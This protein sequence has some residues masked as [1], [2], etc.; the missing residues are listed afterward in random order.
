MKHWWLVVGVTMSGLW[1]T[2][3]C[4][5]GK[6]SGNTGGGTSSTG[7]S[8][9]GTGGQSSSASGGNGGSAADASAS[10][11]GGT[12]GNASGSGGAGT[13]GTAGTGGAN[14]GSAGQGGDNPGP[15]CAQFGDDCNGPD[16]CC[17]GI[18]DA[19]SDTCAR[20]T[21][22]CN[23]TGSNC[24]SN[25]DCCSF[26]CD[27]GECSDQP[28]IDDG[29]DCSASGASCCSGTCN[30]GTCDDVNGG[31]YTCLSAGNSCDDGSDCCSRLCTDGHCDLGSSYCTQLGD[32]CNSNADCCSGTCNMGDGDVGYCAEL[33]TGPNRCADGFAGMVCDGDCARCCSRACGPGP[34]GVVI[35][36]PPSGCRPAGELCQ[37]DTDC[38]GGDDE[39]GLPGSDSSQSFCE[40][41]NEG[42]VFGRCK[43][44]ACTPQGDVCQLNGGLCSEST[45][46]PSN[47]CPTNANPDNPDWQRGSCE[48]DTLGI[49]RCNGFTDDYCVP[50]GGSCSSTSDCCDNRPCVPDPNDN[51]RLKCGENECMESEEGCTTNADCCSGL[52]CVI[53]A[54]EVFG[55]CGDTTTTTTGSGGSGGT[56]GTGGTGGTGT[57]GTGGTTDECAAYGQECTEDSDCCFSAGT[58]QDLGVECLEPTPGTFRC[59]IQQ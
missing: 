47:C 39:A 40:R 6:K 21:L 55:S 58:D 38:C 48:F 44:Q 3:G 19:A 29:E 37:R 34:A 59:L 46:L 45:Q 11:S 7:G 12:A 17:S 35:C 2:G 57:G 23:P 31:E 26:N 54:G 15:V 14:G 8:S 22:E 24:A 1:L 16:D 52:T 53:A 4:G 50:E 9:T 33:E 13:G 5:G 41:E 49:P 10:S 20:N 30:N 28:C 27:G 36:Q 56:T 43:S 25:T 32:I 51:G 18:C 42:D